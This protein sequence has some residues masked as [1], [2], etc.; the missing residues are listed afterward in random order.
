MPPRSR[1]DGPGRVFHVTARV[2]WQVWHLEAPHRSDLFYRV[3]DEALL[4]YSIDLLADV[5]MSNHFHLVVRNPADERY[6]ELTSRKTHCRHVRRWPRGHPNSNVLGQALRRLM[7]TVS[8]KVQEEIGI[9]GH[10]WDGKYHAR[11]LFDADDLV[12]AVAYDHRNPVRAGMVAK[13]EDHLHSSAAWWAGVGSSPGKL[14]RSGTLPFGTNVADLRA[15]I[16][17][18]HGNGDIDEAFRRFRESGHRWDSAA[19]RAH[20]AELLGELGI[21]IDVSRRACRK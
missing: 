18:C 1:E 13:P 3:L 11:R 5:L 17:E 12:L 20:W 21:S 15:R 2:N 9:T 4:A 14:M 8:V 10:F 7:R 16:I 19:G 6:G